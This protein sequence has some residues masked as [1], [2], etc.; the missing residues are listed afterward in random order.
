MNTT[1]RTDRLAARVTARCVA[2][3]FACALLL[4]APAGASAKL[5][6]ELPGVPGE[7]TVA[8]FDKQI[9]LDTFQLSV[10]NPAGTEKVT[11]KPSFSDIVVSKPLDR[12][13]P[14]L[15]LRTA[16][17]EPFPFARVRVTRPSATG[18]STV[19]RYCFT[20]VQVTSFSQSSN[21]DLPSEQVTLSYGTILQ[22]YTPQPAPGAKA[23]EVF[24]SGWDL[25]GNLQ[26]G[27]ACK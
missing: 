3:L 20:N 26:F 7:S 2:L 15:M 19:L 9:E 24:S 22:T 23:G 13:S 10:K 16:N 27:D 4:A 5:F 17:L 12:S 1:S 6:L 18:E 11:G 14:T 25:I 21:G 8:G